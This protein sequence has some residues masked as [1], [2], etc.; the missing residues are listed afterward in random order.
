MKD[1]L[2]KLLMDKDTQFIVEQVKKRKYKKM[3]ILFDLFDKLKKEVLLSEENN[4]LINQGRQ[5]ELKWLF[6][7][8]KEFIPIKKMREILVQDIEEFAPLLR[9][10]IAEGRVIEA[11]NLLSACCVIDY[12]DLENKED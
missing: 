8:I 6:S 2:R 7:E 1:P 4:R 9:Y 5:E 12:L 3:E 10:P 11:E